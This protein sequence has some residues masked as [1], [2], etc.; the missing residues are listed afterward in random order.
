MPRPC[1]PMP[2]LL[3]LAVGPWAGSTHASQAPAVSAPQAPIR[4]QFRRAAEPVRVD[5]ELDEMVWQGPATLELRYETRPADNGPAPVATAFWIAYDDRF[6]YFA[7]RAEDPEP[8]RIRARFSDRDNAFADDFVGLVLDTFHDQRRAFEFFVNPLGVQMDMVQNDVTGEEDETWDALWFSAGRITATGYQ[9]EAAIPLSSL[10]FPPREGAQ[11]WG[12]DAIR[13]WPRD[14]RYRLGLVRLDR[15]RDCYLCQAAELEG[16]QG[17]RPRRDIELDPTLVA[18][19]TDRRGEGTGE[20]EIDPGLTARWG[21]TPHLTLH[22]AVNPDFSQ[23]EADAQQLDVNTQFALFFPEKRPLFLEGADLFSTRINAIYTRNLAD[24]RWA[25]KLTGKVGATGLGLIVAED[26]VTNLLFP[27]SEGSALG[28][29]PDSNVASILRFRR[30]LP[31]P[32]STFGLLYTGREGGDYHN[33]VAGFDLFLRPARGHAA[34]VEALFSSS[35]YPDAIAA[36]FAQPRGR[37]SGHGLRAAY[38]FNSAAWTAYAIYEDRARDFRADLGFIPRVDFRTGVV[39]GER[40]I[41][42]DGGRWFNEIRVGADFDQ[43]WNQRGDLLER[44]TEAWLTYRGPREIYVDLRPVLRRTVLSGMALDER[45]F[46]FYAEGRPGRSLYLSLGGTIGDAIDF[47]NVAEATGYRLDPGL[48]L[49]LG[50]HLRLQLNHSSERLEVA[51]G[52]LFRAELT[53]LNANYQFGLRT[54][55]RLVSQYLAV[56]RQPELYREA[57]PRRTR[58]FGNQLLLSWKLSPQTV[59]FAGYSDIS[60]GDDRVDLVRSARTFFVKL[61]YAWL[62]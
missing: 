34:R 25:A 5:G 8:E 7:A 13:I 43:T 56:D 61:G 54:A 37:F 14:H 11:V 48:R 58:R 38:S 23:V 6:F 10:R 60:L 49:D 62:P 47:A 24:P 16:L 59:A 20:T 28:S 3:W 45:A 50:R 57:V 52:E 39:G 4:Y 36:E 35:A 21:L 26:E 22:A 19:R 2:L 41:Q 1:A 29:I 31:L 33:R 40:I 53:R 30:D 32:G 51:R 9:V 18:A 42:G 46:G 55:V 27:S 15:N 44:E 12:I 17:V